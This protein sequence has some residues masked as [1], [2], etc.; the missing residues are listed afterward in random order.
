MIGTQGGKSAGPTPS[1]LLR[2]LADI[3]Q[4]DIASAGSKAARL[5]S[6]VQAGYS[7]PDGCVLTTMAFRQFVEENQLGHGR[8]TP[9]PDS[10][11]I[12]DSVRSALSSVL[13]QLGTVLLAVRSSGANEDLANASFAGQYETVL[14]VK[15]ESELADA[16]KRCWLSA[17]RREANEYTQMRS[18]GEQ[19]E[20][21]VLIQKL[22]RADAAGVAFTRNP[23]TGA[24]EVVVNAIRGLGD[25]LVSGSVSPDEWL[26]RESPIC[27][28]RKENAISEA[29]AAE[30]ARL[31]RDVERHLGS[32]QDIE[33]AIAGETL[34]LLQA[35]PITTLPGTSED[36]VEEVPVA[37]TVPPGYWTSD[38]E[39]FPRPMSPMFVSYG[40][41]L[42]IDGLRKGAEDFGLPFEGV[43]WKS[44]GGWHYGR[45]V[46][47]GG[48]DRKPPP[49][50]LIRILLRVVPSLRSRVER[51][52]E[53]MRTDR[54]G[55]YAS[56][57]IKEWK[58]ELRKAGDA[59]L[60]VHL[61]GLSDADFNAHL[62]AVL[63]HVRRAMEIHFRY[64]AFALLSV[65]EFAVACQEMLG[66]DKGRVF[67]L[68]AGLSEGDLEP[69]RWLAD[70]ARDARG[71]D[72]LTAALEGVGPSTNIED[73]LAIDPEFDRRFRQFLAE[74]GSNV[75]GYDV[76]DPALEEISL[77]LVGVIRDQIKSNYDPSERALALAK[78]RGEA[79][80]E[81]ERSADLTDEERSR[82][83]RTLARARAGYAIHDD[84]ALCTQHRAAG[85]TRRAL[86]ELGLRLAARGAIRKRDDVF[87]LTFDEAQSA[88]NSGRDLKQLV[89][90]RLG[91]RAWTEANPGPPSYGSPPPAPP[92]DAFPP[93]ARTLLK[94]LMWAI[95][96][97]VFGQRASD[98]R[99]LR[100]VPASAGTYNGIVRVV[101]DQTEFG[102]LQPGDVL[103]CPTTTTVWT[104]V[105]SVIGAL[106]TEAGGT[107][108]HP[109]IVA[110]EYGIPAVLALAGATQK[111]SDG[112]RVHVDGGSGTVSI[113]G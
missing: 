54:A 43:D 86:L 33:W 44:I 103:V 107:L 82:L 34:Y 73:V 25:R 81:I 29:Q 7:V 65:G 110:R 30:I 1:G 78:R 80:R 59:L 84:E 53:S 99:E 87:M 46:P 42:I 51:M 76:I 3:T 104:V 61:P 11:R 112:Q 14:G 47:L 109:A 40:L 58:P 52:G 74:F 49:A 88:F 72:K 77:E 98:S 9:E 60:G 35:R 93:E 23:V 50:S 63:G 24:R 15:G 67:D 108:S 26:V 45:I 32:P 21:A 39:H 10:T 8:E 113:L 66:W 27:T 31:A 22:V 100:G 41:P 90:K 2:G 101:R 71:N 85:I 5:G 18:T 69:S 91:E 111:L 38:R 17:F 19:G 68:L 70:I 55:Q 79:E 6:L 57:W 64:L 20:M 83:L 4:D 56:R 89:K 16:V 28:S 75:L 48:K 62:Q 105:F 37:V 12:P 13:Q 92:L 97:T 36:T 95:E 94:S 106:V 102:K 96:S